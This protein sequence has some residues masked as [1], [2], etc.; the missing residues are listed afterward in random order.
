MPRS[1]WNGLLCH[2]KRQVMDRIV[3]VIPFRAAV[4]FH[5]QNTLMGLAGGRM[6]LQN[7]SEIIRFDEKTIAIKDQRLVDIS[8]I[9]TLDSIKVSAERAGSGYLA[10]VLVC[11]SINNNGLTLFTGPNQR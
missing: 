4:H 6:E 11:D 7:S 9:N 10:N 3:S 8:N 2:T 5:I 1:F